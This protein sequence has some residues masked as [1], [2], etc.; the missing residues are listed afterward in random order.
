MASLGGPAEHPVIDPHY[1]EERADV[2]ALLASLKLSREV[3][4]AGALIEFRAREIAP[5]PGTSAPTKSSSSTACG[6]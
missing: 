4:A 2:R 1:L 5:W 3:G 6:T